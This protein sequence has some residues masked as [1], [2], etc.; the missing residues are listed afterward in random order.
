MKWLRKIVKK[1][2][3]RV[4]AVEKDG[5]IKFNGYSISVIN[6]DEVYSVKIVDLLSFN[7]PK[8]TGPLY[9]D[10]VEEILDLSIKSL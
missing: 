7:P 6:D 3:E 5:H 2:C 8:I 4:D 9:H 1:V 10:E